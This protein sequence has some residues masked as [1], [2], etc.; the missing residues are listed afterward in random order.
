MVV[1]LNTVFG[2]TTLPPLRY[3][4]FE[5]SFGQDEIRWR[6]HFQVLVRTQEHLHRVTQTFHHHG[7]V[8][9]VLGALAMSVPQKIIAENLRC[10][11]RP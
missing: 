10:L 5:E 8:G 6:S 7:V 11:G 4:G 2:A 1:C 3:P 9:N